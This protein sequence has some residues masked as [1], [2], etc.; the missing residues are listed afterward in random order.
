MNT[1][2]KQ[3][4]IVLILFLGVGGCKDKS[5]NE[6]GD[7]PPEYYRF[8][9]N[10]SKK[11]L[12]AKKGSWWTYKNTKSG[13]LDT[14]TVTYFYFD[15]AFTSGTRNY[16]KHITIE[17]DILKRD[18]T[19]SFN[20]WTYR[21]STRAPNADAT[22]ASYYS[23]VINREVSNEG[24]IYPFFYPFNTNNGTGDGST[25]TIFNR[26]DTSVI[27]QGKSYYNVVQFEIDIDNIWYSRLNPDAPF[28][29]TSI[30][31]WA[32]DVGLIKRTNKSEN[33]SWELIDYKIY[34]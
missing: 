3:I 21:E 10:E 13:E 6:T 30:Y 28:N 23:I 31:Y 19:S 7:C 11:Y 4:L 27:I 16:S 25:S 32:I 12:F 14:Q 34:K 29:P 1:Y 20:K 8:R 22:S 9:L 33:Y 26:L 2:S 24:I 18:I 17:Y 5:C 15:S